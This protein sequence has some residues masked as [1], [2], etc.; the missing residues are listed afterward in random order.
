MDTIQCPVCSGWYDVITSET[1]PYCAEQNR[2]KQK[3]KR[4]KSAE[5]GVIRECLKWMRSQPQIIYVERRTTGFFAF[6]GGG[7]ISIGYKGAPDIWCLMGRAENIHV[8]I[9][10]KRRDG[11]GKLSVDQQK[12]QSFCNGACIPHF[13]VTSVNDLK[14]QLRKGGFLT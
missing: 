11:K 6:E 1:C 7:G 10:C 9:E 8:E 14:N 3:Q 12:F 4:S 2:S 13:V 5:A